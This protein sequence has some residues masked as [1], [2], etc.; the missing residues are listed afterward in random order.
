MNS[1]RDA[2]IGFVM[3]ICLCLA[4]A[5]VSAQ[6]TTYIPRDSTYAP[7]DSVP[8]ATD[9]AEIRPPRIIRHVFL[10]SWTLATDD[11]G[12][13][14][15]YLGGA[16]RFVAVPSADLGLM[17]AFSGR[18]NEVYTLEQI[19]PR[20]FLQREETY[21][22]L[23]SLSVDKVQNLMK[24]FGM[25]AGVGIG[26]SW[27]DYDGTE[28]DPESTWTPVVDIGLTG[29]FKMDQGRFVLRVGYQYADR[30]T[31]DKHASYVAIGV[32]F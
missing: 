8:I 29:R 10:F 5:P 1:L 31:T 28:I 20:F 25:Y 26:Y 30:I 15:N 16:Y 17:L 2:L 9:T 18:L 3:L 4:S 19:R 21:R 7:V 24:W 23:A 13:D 12:R 6:R 14:D 22:F 32:G 11:D 27:G